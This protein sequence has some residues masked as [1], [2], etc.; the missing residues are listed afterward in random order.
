M[1][2]SLRGL[3]ESWR[4][5]PDALSLPVLFTLDPAKLGLCEE[6]P[7]PLFA[8]H[9]PEYRELSV[10]DEVDETD[11]WPSLEGLDMF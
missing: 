3:P 7:S 4:E 8:G 2:F 6:L 11:G 10:C 5:T 9:G 1:A